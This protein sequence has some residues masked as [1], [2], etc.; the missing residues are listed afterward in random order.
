MILKDCH[1]TVAFP[2]GLCSVARMKHRRLSAILAL[3]ILLSGTVATQASAFTRGASRYVV[4]FHDGVDAGAQAAAMTNAGMYVPLVFGTLFSG[5]AV[6]LTPDQAAA[7]AGD[8]NVALVEPDVTVKGN[9]TQDGATWGLDRLDQRSTEPD[10]H[11]SY[12]L[13]AGNGVVVYV[14]DSGLMTGTNLH[15]LVHIDLKGRV[16]KGYSFVPDGSGVDDCSG[17]GTSVAGTIAGTQFGVAKL[18]TLFPVRVLDCDN[19]GNMSYVVAALDWIAASRDRS[20]PAVVNLS[21]NGPASQTLDNVVTRLIDSG[22]TVIVSAGNDGANACNYSPA[23]VPTALTVASMNTSE[24]RAEFSNFGPCVDLFAPGMY[25]ESA[26]ENSDVDSGMFAGTSTSAAL[27][28]GIA[29]LLL[30]ENPG[31]TP[32]EVRDQIL[33]VASTG[34]VSNAGEGSPNRFA[35]VVST[36]S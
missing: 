22:V 29:T 34:V 10:G 11:F 2:K 32:A 25:I 27:V 8:P 20:R 17:H 15:N 23:R 1:E 13:S 6:D 12:P 30:G 5:V 4:T 28:S 14:V 18:A 36:G 35:H 9:Q 16:A 19:R 33:S 21:L 3:G 26:R 24:Y 7:L 31:L